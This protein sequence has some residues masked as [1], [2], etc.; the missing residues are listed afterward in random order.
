MLVRPESRQSRPSALGR[1]PP[2][3]RLRLPTA[4]AD[5]AA[6]PVSGRI[7]RRH[8][9]LGI[10]VHGRVARRASLRSGVRGQLWHHSA[11]RMATTPKRRSA[12]LRGMPRLTKAHPLPSTAD[13]LLTAGS[14]REQA[15]LPQTSICNQSQRGIDLSHGGDECCSLRDQLRKAVGQRRLC[16]DFP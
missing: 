11:Y 13:R 9:D 6:Q 14:D 4:S 1:K 3:S 5:A 2:L 8:A 16:V 10:S 12:R 15:L 7:M